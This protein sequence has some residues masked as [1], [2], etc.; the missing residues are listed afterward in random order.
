[1]AY[2]LVAED[3]PVLR[4]ALAEGLRLERHDVM[5]AASA[6]EAAAILAS[7]AVVDLVITDVQMPDWS[8]CGSRRRNVQ[9]PT[10]PLSFG[11]L[12]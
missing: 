10:L 6:D 8:A 9:R 12:Y 7:A 1:M 2:I 11:S 5:E 3:D 4:H